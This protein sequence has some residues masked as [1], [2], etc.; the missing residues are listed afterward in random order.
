MVAINSN[1]MAIG[2]GLVTAM[3]EQE[4]RDVIR[5]RKFF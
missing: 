2:F 4:K 3:T 1:K 5:E